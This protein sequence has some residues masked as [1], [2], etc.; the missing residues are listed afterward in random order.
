MQN[1]LISIIVP[2]YNQAEY[3][4]ECLQSVLNQTYK[5]WECIIVN[6]GSPDN[7][8]ELAKIWIDKDE[9]FKYL[10]KEN[11]GLSS[12]RN[13]GLEKSIG[14][15]I[16]FLDCDDSIHPEK[17]SKSTALIDW[18]TNL[19]LGNFEMI[20]DGIVSPP[21]C[22]ITKYPIT[23]E[24]IILQ[25]DVDFNIP[26]HC[27]IF[28]KESIGDICFNELLHAKEDW[29]FW[30]EFLNQEEICYQLIHETLAF[31]RH[32]SLGLSKN[33]ELIYENMHLANQYIFQNNDNPIKELMFK[34]LNQSVFLL[35]NSILNHKKYIRQL[36]NT[37]VL[38]YYLAFKKLF[39]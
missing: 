4:D 21:F 14:S 3:L 30:I 11:G 9:R 18:K 24:N 12:A 22:D 32:N 7:T 2:C 17:F 27:P 8:E 28:R 25:W 38:K 13:L 33:Y 15:W 6:D 23:L 35:N 29:L 37:K 31:Y 36:Q 10:N 34:K 1:P 26:I 39:N 19:I 5:N 20:F 16:Q